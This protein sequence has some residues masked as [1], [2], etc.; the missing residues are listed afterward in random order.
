MCAAAHGCQR[1][2]S[3]PFVTVTLAAATAQVYDKRLISEALATTIADLVATDLEDAD[4]CLSEAVRS[5][6]VQDPEGQT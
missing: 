2:E 4:L 6:V 5:I 1:A 3:G